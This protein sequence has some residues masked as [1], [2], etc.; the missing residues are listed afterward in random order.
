M[1]FKKKTQ[2]VEW[3]RKQMAK[4]QVDMETYSPDS[5]QY[6]AAQESWTSF[7]QMLD[8]NDPV[9]TGL[10]NT[11]FRIAEG[12]V[13]TVVCT[14]TESFGFLVPTHSLNNVNLI[15]KFTHRKD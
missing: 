9:K 13:L 8:K 11:V 4:L 6:K 14:L 2:D 7:A 15:Q 3:I 1:F 10:I 12:S 5:Q